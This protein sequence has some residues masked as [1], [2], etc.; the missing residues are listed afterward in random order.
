MEN[1]NHPLPHR[2]GNGLRRLC[3]LAAAIGALAAGV[4]AA[5]PQPRP[6]LGTIEECIE[7]GTDAV[8][9]PGVA[10]GT[11]SASQ[12]AGCPTLR[13]RFDA[14]TRYF[15]GKQPVTYAQ[16]REAAKGDLQLDVFYHPKTRILTRLRLPAAAGVQ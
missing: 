13:L 10:G 15:I 14:K 4:V 6:R 11:L 3:L 1:R 9:L 5:E 12:C 8:S 16:F 2:A 7:S